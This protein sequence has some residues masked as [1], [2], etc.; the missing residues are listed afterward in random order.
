MI[1]NLLPFIVVVIELVTLEQ[2]S[3]A[4]TLFVLCATVPDFC[5]LS[6]TCNISVLAVYEFSGVHLASWDIC[7]WSY[8]CNTFCWIIEIDIFF[9]F[10]A[11]DPL[12]WLR[13][14]LLC[15][16]D[17]VFCSG[18]IHLQNYLVDTNRGG[19]RIS[20]ISWLC[21]VCGMKL[22][23]SRDTSKKALN[24]ESP[25][26]VTSKNFWGLWFQ[27]YTKGI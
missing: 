9:I 10:S 27:I 18:F 23:T 13:G 5:L 16:A 17:L 12:D 24:L 7:K 15:P 1:F 19:Y 8:N 6:C 3:L 4:V 21:L 20:I 22:K 14:R 25:L 11:A 26:S 2:V